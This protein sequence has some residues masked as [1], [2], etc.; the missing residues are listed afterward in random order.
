MAGGREGS[1]RDGN[2]PW[3]EREVIGTQQ[4][5]GF[6]VRILLLSYLKEKE[7]LGRVGGATGGRCIA[8]DKLPAAHLRYIRMKGRVKRREDQIIGFVHWAALGF[9]PRGSRLGLE[10]GLLGLL[11]L[12]GGLPSTD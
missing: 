1:T 4:R 10:P 5:P 7:G 8:L 9:G 3:K 2:D 6:R 12:P 11:G